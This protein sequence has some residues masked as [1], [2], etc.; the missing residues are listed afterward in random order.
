MSLNT[1]EPEAEEPNDVALLMR[2]SSPLVVAIDEAAVLTPLMNRRN[3]SISPIQATRPRSNPR[4]RTPMRYESPLGGDDYRIPETGAVQINGEGNAP[5]RLTAGR[6]VGT[7][8][9]LLR[10]GNRVSC[11]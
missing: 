5:R 8:A 2:H 10:A 6:V 4:T 7:T 1:D 3:S 9:P 11:Q